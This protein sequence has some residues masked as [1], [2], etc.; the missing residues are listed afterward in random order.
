MLA[1]PWTYLALLSL[2]YGLALT[3][4]HLGWFA[5]IS[6]ALLLIAGFAVRQQKIRI[7]PFLGHC[8]FIF[9]ALALAMHWLPG[10]YN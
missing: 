8:L 4:G 7:A 5:G 1:L 9:M 6:V 2:D 3:Y 10:F